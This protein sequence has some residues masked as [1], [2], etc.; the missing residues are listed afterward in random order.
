MSSILRDDLLNVQK[1]ID[2]IVLETANKI[3][4]SKEPAQS[5]A[6]FLIMDKNLLLI[7]SFNLLAFAGNGLA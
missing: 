1:I 6:K 7:T 4:I 3:E 2:N 5:H